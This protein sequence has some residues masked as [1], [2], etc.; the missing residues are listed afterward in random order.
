MESQIKFKP[1]NDNVA[2]EEVY[3]DSNKV[4]KLT[5]EELSRGIV[6]SKGEGSVL[7]DGS[8]RPI[9]LNVGDVVLFDDK[10]S[11]KVFVGTKELKVL[12]LRYIVGKIEEE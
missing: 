3:T 10:M 12:E 6:V 11:T 8:I 7:P 9:P 2:L 1:F 4:L 5:D